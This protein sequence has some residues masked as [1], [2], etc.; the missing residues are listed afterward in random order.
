[1]CEVCSGTM[2]YCRS[3][4][5]RGA[6]VLMVG[7]RG[8]AA[9][10]SKNVVLAGVKSLTV[11]DSRPLSAEDTA[12]RFLCMTVGEKVSAQIRKLP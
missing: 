4:R 7:L 11:L 8:L 3:S 10:V 1:M 9:E 5:L 2:S 6:R 12:A